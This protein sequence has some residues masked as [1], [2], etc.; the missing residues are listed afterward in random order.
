MPNWCANMLEI[1]GPEEDKLKLIEFVKPKEGHNQATELSLFSI[2][3]YEGEWD[4]DWCVEN[5]GTKWDVNATLVKVDS[6][7]NLVYVFDS[8]WGPP[9]AVI[10]RLAELFPTLQFTHLFAEPGIG[11]HGCD[12][13]NTDVDE[14]MSA[15]NNGNVA[16]IIAG[17][18]WNYKNG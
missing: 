11:F 12:Q 16:D 1:A 6:S 15:T 17:Y 3:P 13:Y 9:D 5:W 2:I 10:Q 8:A 18:I 14:W 4:Y 7:T